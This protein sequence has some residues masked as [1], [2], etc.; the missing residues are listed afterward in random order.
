MKTGERGSG[1][2]VVVAEF[3]VLEDQITAFAALMQHHAILSRTEPGCQ[4]FEVTQD[5]SDE[6]NFLLFERYSNAISYD[7]HRAT[8]H[9]ARFREVA[10]AMLMPHAGSIFSRRSVLLALA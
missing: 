8:A 4:V 7:A 10:P 3:V 6:R 1:G 9:Y 2:Y 5:P